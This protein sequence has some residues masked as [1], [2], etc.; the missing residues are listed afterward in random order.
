LS[1]VEHTVAIAPL[2][3]SVH[4]L[5]VI[6]VASF[7]AVT[8]LSAKV[9]QVLAADAKVGIAPKTAIASAASFMLFSW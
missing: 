5:P 6:A 4:V 7:A 1:E 2:F 8:V 3:V 9:P